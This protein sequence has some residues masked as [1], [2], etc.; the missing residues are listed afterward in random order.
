METTLHRFCLAALTGAALMTGI[1]ASAAPAWEVISHIDAITD[2]EVRRARI[3]NDE[4]HTFT[5]SRLQSGDAQAIFRLSNRTLDQLSSERLPVLRV[6]KN[7]PVELSAL[8]AARLASWEPKWVYFVIGQSGRPITQS[9]L[10]SLM[11]GEQVLI[12][13]FLFTGG[14]KDTVFHLNGA[15]AAIAD[16]L[17]M[18]NPDGPLPPSADAQRRQHEAQAACENELG[19]AK[20]D[21][22][23]K[24]ADCTNWYEG[25][26]NAFRQ[27]VAAP[28]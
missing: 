11:S 17:G 7:A 13:Y 22:Y 2:A 21:C 10:A 15:R 5:I 18:P 6:D 16:A 25:N 8:R 26:P 9:I 3:R 20:D 23:S 1:P 12:R 28:R 27:C 19:V 4:G 24:V 14:Y